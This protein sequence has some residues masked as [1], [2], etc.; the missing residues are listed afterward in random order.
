VCLTCADSEQGSDHCPVY[1]TFKDKVEVYQGDNRATEL[2]LLDIMN[3]SGTFKNGLRQKPW[4]TK[5]IPPTSGKLLPEF[6]KR[7][8]IKDMFKKP[9]MNH[10]SSS[11]QSIT[12]VPTAQTDI[13]AD[14]PTSVTSNGALFVASA[15]SPIRRT[16]PPP[17]SAV[18]DNKRKTPDLAVPKSTKRSKANG[19]VTAS[20]AEAG[21]G[22]KSLMGFFAP[23]V[24]AG[25][26]TIISN[27]YANGDGTPVANETSSADASESKNDHANG[28]ES[29]ESNQPST[30]RLKQHDDSKTIFLPSTPDRVTSAITNG[31]SAVMASP[32]TASADGSVHDPIVSKESWSKLLRKPA[33]PLCEHGEPCKSMLTK[34]KGENQGRSFW[35][36]QHPLGPSGNK[37]RGTQWRCHTFIWCSDYKGDG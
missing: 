18:A 17:S 7:R 10:S 26:D 21:K 29:H 35:M 36:C 16:V 33:A 27:A 3:P 20:K 25:A 4:S 37:E 13:D 31:D 5:D 22:Q 9:T 11:S 34:K 8:S 15:T 28:F 14:K 30:E 32:S 1:A 24:K 19:A 23:K 2:H 6:D 12:V